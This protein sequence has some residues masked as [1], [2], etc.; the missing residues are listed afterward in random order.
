MRPSW[1]EYF[2]A[3]AKIISTRSTCNSRP[4]GAVIVRDK[5]ILSTGYNGAM[6]GAPH[7]IDRI[8]EDGRPFCFRRHVSA[9]EGDKYNFCRS[10]HAEANAVARAAKFGI[11]LDGS[12]LF[13]TLSPC[14]VCIKQLA[15]AGVKHIYFEYSYEST[16]EKRDRLW[17]TVID[18]SPIET[19]E[20]LRVSEHTIHKIIEALDYPT[21][22][23]R[24][25][26]DYNIISKPS[27][28]E[29]NEK[30][31]GANNKTHL[32]KKAIL[33]SLT[34]EEVN[35]NL[36]GGELILDLLDHIG[37]TPIGIDKESAL[38][39]LKSMK[40]VTNGA[41]SSSK[42][43]IALIDCLINKKQSS[44]H[45]KEQLYSLEI[46]FDLNSIAVQFT[47]SNINVLCDF[48]NA[49][50]ASLIV[51]REILDILTDRVSL[52]LRMNSASL[53]FV[54]SYIKNSEKLLAEER[55]I[56]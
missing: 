23:R 35:D 29:S 37:S 56:K 42:P 14:Y 16:D 22:V 12:S 21:S 39:Y 7:C 3:I 25:S 53:A 17:R 19:F 54:S 6:P 55:L 20:E 28:S 9:P 36:V 4:T 32:F 52:G 51:F 18:E 33:N 48:F 1:K 26:E 41:I 10:S 5:Q 47:I 46:K 27:I 43:I 15:N 30:L 13:V 44:F 34:G 50:N 8:E 11:Q 45:F 2:M 40:F 31:A 49:F 38:I 24:L